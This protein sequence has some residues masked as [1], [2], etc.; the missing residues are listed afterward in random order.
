MELEQAAQWATIVGAPCAVL[1]LIYAGL[2]L[3]QSVL[4]ARGQFMLELERM[5][6]LHDPVHIRLEGKGIWTKPDSGPAGNSEWTALDDYMGFF[7]HCELL[8]QAGSLKLQSFKDLFGYRV[9]NIM[10]NKRIVKAK[11]IEEK[12]YWRLFLKL[13]DRLGIDR[14]SGAS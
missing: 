13:L 5:I 11:L 6:T 8:L 10:M 14:P 2:Q 3:R 4:I 12:K 1:A 9:A 7:E